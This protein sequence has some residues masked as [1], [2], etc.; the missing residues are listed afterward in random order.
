VILRARLAI[1][2]KDLGGFAVNLAATAWWLDKFW[3]AVH[4]QPQP[5]D[6]ARSSAIATLELPTV[7]FPLQYAPLVEAHRLGSISYRTWMIASGEVK[8]R[9]NENVLTQAAVSDAISAAEPAVLAK[10]R[11]NIALVKTS[12]EGIRN[13]FYKH[14][15]AAGLDKLLALATTIRE[16]IDPQASA[17]EAVDLAPSG[18]AVER[19]GAAPASP[20][21]VS[22]ALAAIADYYSRSEPSSP[23][24]LLVR[25]AHQLIG[26]SFFEA[27]SILV[28]GY[29]DKAAFQI[30]GDQFF[31]LPLQKLSGFAR[32]PAAPGDG[33]AES[34]PGDAAPRYTVTSRTQAIVLLDQIQQYFRRTEPSSPVPMLC[35]RARALAE[36][37]FMGVLRDVLPKDALKTISPDKPK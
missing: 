6:S 32:A 16:F 30:G 15:D 13:A 28:P 27:I 23:I 19:A 29:V 1:V 9:A 4:P 5:G 3:D 11:R 21:E 25:Q 26:K 20:A 31:P 8:P 36:R 37:D 12:L 33:Q 24:L 10:T 22:E 17:A 34:A 7:I 35:E 2:N 14:G 18:D